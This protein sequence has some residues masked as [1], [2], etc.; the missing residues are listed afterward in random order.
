MCN[1]LQVSL[2]TD[3]EGDYEDFVDHNKKKV[4]DGETEDGNK[5]SI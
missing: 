4:K 3:E 2:R 5:E 1:F